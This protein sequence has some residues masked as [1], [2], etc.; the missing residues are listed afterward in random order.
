MPIAAAVLSCLIVGIT[1]GDTLTARCD[2][3]AGQLEQTIRVR[4][5]EIDAPEKAQPFGERSRQHLAQLCFRRRAELALLPGSAGLDRY[6]RAAAA[7]LLKSGS[8]GTLSVPDFSASNC[9]SRV[10]MRCRK[11]IE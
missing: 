5:A 10:T 8:A 3:A 9:C 7:R 6:A 11:G 4:L 1:D 2:A